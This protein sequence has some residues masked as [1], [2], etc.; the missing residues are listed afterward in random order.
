M[1]NTKVIAYILT[2]LLL[3]LQ[4]GPVMAGSFSDVPESSSDYTLLENLKTIG[5]VAG[6]PD[7]TFQPDL[8]VSRAEALKMILKA[9]D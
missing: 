1:K 3:S 6:Y 5:V 2:L 7:G 9:S 4:V 8:P